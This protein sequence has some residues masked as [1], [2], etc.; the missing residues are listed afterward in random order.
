MSKG[1]QRT[2]RSLW[3][4][5]DWRDAGQGWEARQSTIRLLGWK[6]ERRVVVLRRPLKGELAVEDQAQ[7]WLGFIEARST[8]V[9]T[10][11]YAVLVTSLPAERCDLPMMS[12]LYRDRADC[13]NGFDELK[14]QWGWGGFTTQD[15]GRCR[16][17]A[18]AVALIYN[19]WNLYLRMVEPRK[20]LEA[21]AAH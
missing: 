14:N 2:V 6:R 20:H 15:F 4:C 8:A 11:E 13:E 16:L 10:Y 1:V 7:Q 5:E 21:V 18:Q 19:W 3:A 12:Q 9:Q 17:A